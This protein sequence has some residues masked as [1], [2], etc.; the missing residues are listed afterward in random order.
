MLT[1]DKQDRQWVEETWGKTVH[2]LRCM[3]GRSASKIPFTVCNGVHD[4]RRVD[5]INCWTNGFWGGLLWLMYAATGEE[6]YREIAQKQEQMLDAAFENYDALNHD[7]GFLWHITSGAHYRLTGDVQSKT[8]NLYAANLLAGRYRLNGGYIRAWNG[9]VD[10]QD[11][12]G[13]TIIDCMMNLPLLYWA[14]RETGDDR[15]RQIAMAHADKAMQSHV[16][17]DGSVAHIVSHDL[18]TGVVLETFGGQGYAAGSSW[19][20]GQAWALYG[21]VLSYIHTGK[22]AY[23]DTA[24][25]VAHYFIAC[26]CEDFLPKCDF[27]APA[28]PAIMDASAGAIAA[29]GLIEIANSVSEYERE[30]YLRAAIRILKALDAHCCNWDEADDAIVY[31]CMDYYHLAGPEEPGHFIYADYFFTEAMYKLK[32]NAILF[33]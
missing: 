30:I 28:D 26:V 31:G 29:C 4:D 14:S 22:Q 9:C 7:V 23:L 12:T 33:W 1:V 25:Q 24:K 19:S 15:Y 18:D 6:Q 20:R 16:R 11:T 2:K 3:A 32:G 13:W 27:R 5:N 21:F 8:R 10:G 17:A